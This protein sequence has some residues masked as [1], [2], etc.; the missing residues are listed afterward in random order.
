MPQELRGLRVCF[1]LRSNP[2]FA[3][4][5]HHLA[6]GLRE[7]GRP[8]FFED[9]D[10][11]APLKAVP[12]TR[13]ACVIGSTIERAGSLDF[14]QRA[15]EARPGY[16]RYVALPFSEFGAVDPRM[17]QDLNRYDMV[18][19]TSEHQ[20]MIFAAHGVREQLLAVRTI[21]I[22]AR[23]YRWQERDHKNKPCCFLNISN[24]TESEG[25]D[26]L[27]KAFVQTFT[28]SCGAML[29]ILIKTDVEQAR[30]ELREVYSALGIDESAA[31]DIHLVGWSG[32]EEE[33]LAVYQ[34][35][36]CYLAPF[37]S[38][39]LNLRM[40]E[41]AATGLPV[42]APRWGS[43]PGL[44]PAEGICWLDI[45]KQGEVQ[46]TSLAPQLLTCPRSIYAEPSQ[47]HLS[48][49]LRMLRESPEENGRRG[50]ANFAYVTQKQLA[51]QTAVWMNN[52]F[53]ESSILDARPARRC[54]HGPADGRIHIGF[55]MR[56]M[57]YPEVFERGIGHYAVNHL[58]ALAELLPEYRFTMFTESDEPVVPLL[59]LAELPNVQMC[60][61][62]DLPLDPPDLYHIPDP[63]SMLPHYDSPFRLA[64]PG[65][66]LSAL[67]HDLIPLILH[68]L[69][70]DLWAPCTRAAYFTRLDQM[71]RSNALIL[72]NSEHT[73]KDLHEHTSIP[74]ERIVAVMA[75]LNQKKYDGPPS[76]AEI[77]AVL[78]RYHLTQPFFMSVGALD[79]HK[80]PISMFEAFF[81]T[82]RQIPSLCLAIVGSLRDP[83]KAAYKKRIEELGGRGVVFCGFVPSDDL[84]CLYA[85]SAGLV[86][87]SLYEGFGFPVLEAMANSCPVIT[88]NVSSI[89]EVAGDACVLVPPKD[90]TAIHRAML[91]LANDR[92]FRE[93]R[94]AAGLQQ[95]ARF[96]WRKTAERTRDAWNVHFNLS[97][98]A[99]VRVA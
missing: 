49:L 52:R 16:Q 14:F 89:P 83:F 53:I 48:Q 18:W 31:P 28:R 9:L 97:A 30:S 33:L 17:V 68:E 1:P 38:D 55:D 12:V 59:P 98:A 41:A 86:F 93:N 21:G 80:N 56:S 44:L 24:W 35:A 66:P 60:C 73:R 22:D 63:V 7:L 3:L 20:R 25:I 72:T 10:D 70:S 46:N 96:S 51:A 95:A 8:I 76:A 65:R 67:F 32:D 4:V 50:R 94:T 23:S 54:K 64:P 2:D 11:P 79:E 84:R 61:Y 82:Q 92:E 75:G 62:D 34:S 88:T 99:R 58:R 69:H 47:A 26:I 40:V 45:E 13:G 87:P 29:L 90:S 5:K 74:L 27:I 91:R 81:E 85:S 78:A 19:V 37:R 71:R 57:A 15:R 39:S 77:S 42:V 36:D 6:P 43:F